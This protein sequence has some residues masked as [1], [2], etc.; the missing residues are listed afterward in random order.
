MNPTSGLHA[1]EGHFMTQPPA[2]PEIP[3]EGLG[4]LLDQLACNG[5]LVGLSS[6]IDPA[7]ARMDWSTGVYNR[8]YLEDLVHEAITDAR[9][10][11]PRILDGPEKGRVAVVTIRI[12][13]WESVLLDRGEAVQGHLETEAARRL[14]SCLRAEDSLARVGTDTFALLLRGCATN[15]LGGIAERCKSVIIS[16]PFVTPGE[17]VQLEAT[18]TTTSWDGEDPADFTSR[19]LTDIAAGEAES[20]APPV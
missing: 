8:A 18:A 5:W 19:A 1:S 14:A 15:Q 17:P 3:R 20:H 4:L 12:A 2:P 9:A 7:I 13:N 10:N 16:A 6:D 11:R